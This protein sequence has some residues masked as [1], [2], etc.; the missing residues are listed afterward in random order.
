M[1][2]FAQ[3]LPMVVAPDDSNDDCDN[4][5]AEENDPDHEEG[6]FDHPG[7]SFANLGRNAT[8][9]DCELGDDVPGPPSFINDA[10]GGVFAKL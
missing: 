4:G 5:S 7:S 8:I 10:K 9:K 2:N 3:V 6:P 1:E